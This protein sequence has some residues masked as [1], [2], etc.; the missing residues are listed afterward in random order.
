VSSKQLRALERK[1]AAFK[2]PQGNQ[3]NHSLRNAIVEHIA[4]TRA[5]VCDIDDVIVTSG[6]QQAFDLLA[7]VLVTP[8][9]TAVATED[10]GYPPM[11]VAFAAAGARV[12]P[13][14]VDDE[15]LIVEKIP[16]DVRVIC[17]SPSHQF[18][19]GL[20]TSMRRRKALVAFA[21]ANNAVIVEDDYDGEFRFA[22]GAMEALRTAGAADVVFYVGTF[23][24]CM[25]PSLR[26]GFLV[27][28]DWAIKTLV[29]AKNCMDWHCPT[30]MQIGIAGFIAEGHLA[31]HVRKLRQIYRERRHVL[32]KSLKQHLEKW[33][34]PLPSY[35]G[36]HV[37]AVARGTLDCDRVAAS[38]AEK[39]IKI[40][41]LSRYFLGEKSM[42]G[43]VF[44]YGAVTSDQIEDGIRTMR[45]TI[46]DV[47]G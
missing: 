19:L 15:G 22:G 37:A 35:Y 41:S 31:R 26:T 6:A 28:P 8:N 44:G 25:L 46:A 4:L 43:F 3:G 34:E 38:L 45:K 10:P 24:K 11:R 40:H 47:S 14:A 18:P 12:I 33:I 21:R 13:V 16:A 9:E 29:A 5:V 30:P 20:T 32:L 23:S 17:L 36:T 39:N 27:A 7:R 42:S 1:P 2:S